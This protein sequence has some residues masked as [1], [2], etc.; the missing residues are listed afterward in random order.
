MTRQRALTGLVG[1]DELTPERLDRVVNPARSVTRDTEP[2]VTRDTDDLVVQLPLDSITSSPHQ[3]RRVF[4]DAR[5]NELA[6]SIRQH[7]VL[8]PILVRAKEGRG[9]E[10][11]A[12]ERR[13][14]ASRLAG[15]PTIRAVVTGVDDLTSA[16]MALAENLA[17][18]DLNPVE[19][20]RGAAALRD[21]FGLSVTAIAK[22]AGRDRTAISHLIRLLELPDQVIALLETGQLTEGHGRVLLQ[23]DDHGQRRRIARRC[24]KEG[25][26]VR[27]LEHHV[28]SPTPRSPRPTPPADL[29]D[30]LRHLTET[31]EP[32]FGQA[33][34][35]IRPRR[36]GSYELTVRLE[37]YDSLQAVIGHLTSTA[38][39]TAD[40]DT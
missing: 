7:G 6:H 11:I 4:D 25:W 24:V 8:Q 17:R 31:L 40:R 26:S 37:D 16:Q 29:Q 28:H 35:N 33:P 30:A 14:R 18:T 1:L 3:P 22:A 39:H 10:L 12:G 9:F 15:L 19:A 23:I 20:A 5:L 34:V 27:E 38:E 2:A 32:I 13:L 36:H 21:T